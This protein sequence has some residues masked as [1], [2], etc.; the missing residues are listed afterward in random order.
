MDLY[1]VSQ[2]FAVVSYAF[3]ASTYILKRRKLILLFNFGF[4]A[5]GL[6][7]FICLSAWVGVAMY[8]IGFIRSIIFILQDKKNK[9]ESIDKI[10]WYI[11]A[12]LSLITLVSGIVLYDGFFSLFSMFATLIY[13]VS[14][15]QKNTK[16]YRILGIP[17]SVLWICY[18]VY[19]SSLFGIILEFCL[20]LCVIVGL[21]HYCVNEKR[22][23]N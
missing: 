9:S 21:I 7:S 23:S 16:L 12:F 3:L 18:H 2:L 4:L 5:A 1:V 22:T 17:V 8:A 6:I 10:D 20:L 14:V 15:W 11:L 19:I 13:T